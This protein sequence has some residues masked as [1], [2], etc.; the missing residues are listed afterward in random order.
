MSGD[1][2]DN[3]SNVAPDMTTAN[4]GMS[5]SSSSSS[6]SSA[7]PSAP[8]YGP[9]TAMPKGPGYYAQSDS[10]APSAGVNQYGVPWG[11]S[12]TEAA[13][14]ES[15]DAYPMSSSLPPGSPGYASAW[16]DWH[17]EYN[18]SGGF[19]DK[20]APIIATAVA[21][22]G[23]MPAGIGGLV[24]AGAE[25]APYV[26][27]AIMGG[28]DAGVMGGD[29]LQSAL[30]SG[31]SSYA[32]N[33]LGGGSPAANNAI[34]DVGNSGGQA[35]GQ[36]DGFTGQPIDSSVADMA[37]Q[38]QNQVDNGAKLASNS[39]GPNTVN[40]N[41]DPTLNS[42]SSSSYTGGPPPVDPAFS[43]LPPGSGS[44]FGSL[45]NS[46]ANVGGTPGV[47][48]TGGLTTPNPSAFA[49][50]AGNGAQTS[51]SDLVS[52]GQYGDAAARALKSLGI[53]GDGTFGLGK[54]AVPLGMMAMNALKK[55]VDYSAQL[56]GAGTPA[57]A[58]NGQTQQMINQYNAGQLPGD[59]Q[60]QID[61]WAQSQKAQLQQYFSQAGLSN[62]TQ[63]QQAIANVDVQ[64]Q[65]KKQSA[66]ANLL[67]SAQ[68]AASIPHS[69]ALSSANLQ[70]NQ[71]ANQQKLNQEL[72][73]ALAGGAVGAK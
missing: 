52:N 21:A 10:T 32:S 27:S 41:T 64:A 72:L 33:A 57:A 44:N 65:Q 36:F 31:L 48:D 7:T 42:L 1:G 18:P 2:G 6:S 35:V 61:Q 11:T 73:M 13:P 23:G 46:G 4:P 62:S 30:T 20:I 71:D 51:F 15:A 14:Q 5:S 17:P 67:T 40:D 3:S 68:S 37:S 9:G 47:Q 53:T 34:A 25:M 38:A 56:N 29:P 55:P 28:I 50:N 69:V 39:G 45:N 12:I 22:M 59:Q 58:L 54:N 26:G 63:A 8:E 49:P 66:L 24:G 16:N 19:G 70:M 43:L 60:A